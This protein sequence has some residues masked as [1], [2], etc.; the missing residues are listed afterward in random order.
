[1]IMQLVERL[2]AGTTLTNEE[3]GRKVLET[4]PMDL[5]LYMEQVWKAAKGPDP[6]PPALDLDNA[7][8]E[9]IA[10]GG[11]N[12]FTPQV[13]P[14]L[15]PW[16][17]LGYAY[18]LE[19]TRAVQILARIV[20][21][22]RSGEALGI[23]SVETQQ[24]VEAT[25]ALLFGAANPFTAWLSTSNLRKDPESVRRNAYWRLFGLDLAFGNDDNSA[26]TYEK[27]HAANTGFAA[28]FEELLFELWQAMSNRRNFAGANQ[29][30]DDR[31]FRIAEQ[32]RYSLF[33]RRQSGVLYREELSAVTALGWAELTVSF[34][35]PVVLDLG[36]NAT[37]PADRLRIMGERVGLAAHSKSAAFFSM[38]AELSKLLRVIESG[39]VSRA[40]KTWILYATAKPP[41]Q[42]DQP[43]GTDTRR[44]ITE[45]AAATGKNLK[46]RSKP[47]DVR[48]PRLVAVA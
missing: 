39:I 43:I 40:D 22:Y 21:E 38:A 2:K 23:P 46:E 28:L 36:A 19:N 18:A 47:V 42:A 34:D 5:I 41:G 12:G 9:L 3:A 25:E 30:D 7:R 16:D 1:M 24:W 31:I 48:Q 27:A 15:G 37:S 26:P 14:P 17:H 44:V 45:W 4:D 29:S 10:S 8:E 13:F 33:S 11:C 6:L 20:R 35:T 32:L